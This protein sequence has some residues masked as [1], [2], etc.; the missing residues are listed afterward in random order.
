MS[1]LSTVMANGLRFAYIEEGE[2]PL[3]VMLH[4][5][6]DTAHSWDG[7][8]PRVAALGF[9]VVTPFTRGY[10]PTQIPSEEAYDADTLGRDALAL[11]DALGN[12]D[13][14]AILIGHDFGAS[15]TYS[16]LGL[17]PE[18]LRF[19]ITMAIPH[20]ASMLPTPKLLWSVRHFFSLGRKG[21]SRWVE[22]NDYAHIDELVQRWSPDWENIPASETAAVKEAFRQPGCLEAALGYY[23]ALKP[24]LP[25]SQRRKVDVPCAAIAGL[26]DMIPPKPYH[27]AKSRYRAGYEVLEVPGGH[28]MHREHPEPFLQA[29]L[30]LLERVRD[31]G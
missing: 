25:A 23:R 22:K 20:P 2:G 6:P 3:V 15:A 21:A 27:K 26:N 1:E 18:K 17:G 11:I 13:E 28:F 29:L 12:D 14:K 9:R 19:A 16:A 30:P 10:A 4:G 31:E 8:R 5:F 24:G 7:V